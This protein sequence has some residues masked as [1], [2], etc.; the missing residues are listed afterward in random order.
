[1]LLWDTATG[2]ERHRFQAGEHWC[3]A[4]S[5][6]GKLL[7]TGGLDGTVLLWDMRK[8]PPV[9]AATTNVTDDALW[10]DL[11]ADAPRAYQ[12]II[13]LSQRGD[14]GV[15]VLRDR[16]K[17]A[18]PV[19]PKHL[20]KLIDDLDDPSFAVRKKATAELTAFHDRAAPALKHRLKTARS[21]EMR[22]SIQQ[23]LEK[24]DG[25][26]TDPDLLRQV[27][28]VEALERTDAPAAHRLL[29]ELSKGDPAARLTRE[30]SAALAHT[31]RQEN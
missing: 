1:M 29:E 21:A 23:L 11:A 16:L 14:H 28:A 6:D 22:R 9:G 12:A 18:V 8:V 31:K 30:A 7:A 15:M 24:L 20:V 17:P 10:A 5:P 26:L 19:D 2:K 13:T 27:R 4:F 3:F 25:L